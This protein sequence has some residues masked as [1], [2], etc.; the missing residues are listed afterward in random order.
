MP[1]KAHHQHF[2]FQKWLLL[3]VLFLSAL[4]SPANASEFEA[5][6]TFLALDSTLEQATSLDDSSYTRHSAIK[7]NPLRR[8]AAGWIRIQLPK[9]H[10]PQRLIIPFSL[11]THIDAYAYRIDNTVIDYKLGTYGADTQYQGSSL[12]HQIKLD[13]KLIN[14]DRPVFLKVKTSFFLNLVFDLLPESEYNTLDQKLTSLHKLLVGLCLAGIFAYAGLLLTRPSALVGAILAFLTGLLFLVLSA[15]SLN[16]ITTINFQ[17]P[18]L[19]RI[20]LFVVPFSFF[21]L[22][23]CFRRLGMLAFIAPKIDQSLL[24]AQSVSLAATLSALVLNQDTAHNFVLASMVINLCII[25]I[26]ALFLLAK[27]S[28]NITVRTVILIL[29]TP[30][31]GALLYIGPAYFDILPGTAGHLVLP[32]ALTIMIIGLLVLVPLISSG[33]LHH[34]NQEVMAAFKRKRQYMPLAMR[35]SIVVLSFGLMFILFAT[36]FQSAIQSRAMESAYR[37]STTMYY[38]LIEGELKNLLV[39]KGADTTAIDKTVGTGN[40][41]TVQLSSENKAGAVIYRR[42]AE[43]T[44]SQH[45]TY[46]EINAHGQTGV[47]KISLDATSRTR[48]ERAEHRDRLISNFILAGVVSIF[49]LV[50]FRILVTNHLEVM[51]Q[52]LSQIELRKSSSPLK[53]IRDNEL[54]TDELDYLGSA[55]K[56]MERDLNSSYQ[57][58]SISKTALEREV[59]QRTKAYKEVLEREHRKRH[60]VTM[61]L[62]VAAVAHELR[63]PLGTLANTAQLIH[64]KFGKDHPQLLKRMQRSIERCNNVIEELRVISQ[65]SSISLNTNDVSQWLILALDEYQGLHKHNLQ[66][67]V[68]SGIQASIDKDKMEQVLY[69]LLDNARQSIKGDATNWPEFGSIEV[70]LCNA[71]NAALELCVTDNGPGIPT[72][73]KDKIF[74]PLITSKPSGFGMGLSIALDI[75]EQHEGHLKL[76]NTEDGVRASV[77]LPVD[78]KLVS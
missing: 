6:S 76:E 20:A 56:K 7:I 46:F 48:N 10:E 54:H 33:R 36:V 64:H 62:M 50:V 73:I 47:A 67:K 49:C 2:Y 71:S 60:L 28:R 43:E 31:L 74:E 17:Y 19:Q 4:L 52:H 39:D 44:E 51:A 61:G 63:N 38:M 65:Q 66:R 3:F 16:L 9:S 77:I 72:H 29:G 32:I 26:S 75:V 11:S 18:A 69:I 12:G 34:Q 78:P 59:E 27:H 5:H 23:F 22:A 42:S 55:I 13:P 8:H 70:S 30:S 58:L 14:F 40:L 45:T 25:N 53:L 37:Q 1:N 68:Q 41:V 57:H 15:I 24:L 21:L 35:Y